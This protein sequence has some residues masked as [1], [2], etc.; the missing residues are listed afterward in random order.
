MKWVPTWKSLPTFKQMNDLVRQN[1]GE[2]GIGFPFKGSFKPCF[3]A[4]FFEL[5]AYTF[6]LGF[7]HS[8]GSSCHQIYSCTREI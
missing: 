2:Q 6:L 3:S 7:I 8:Q 5:S 4:I 1:T